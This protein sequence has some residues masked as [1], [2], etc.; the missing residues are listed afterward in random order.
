MKIVDPVCPKIEAQ[1]KSINKRECPPKWDVEIG[2]I[3]YIVI[4]VV[5]AIFKDRWLIWIGATAYFFLWKSGFLNG[6][7][8]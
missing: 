7:K 1:S 5:G 2:W 4:M 8:K 3:W 6:G